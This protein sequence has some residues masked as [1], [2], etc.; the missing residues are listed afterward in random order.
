MSGLEEG[1]AQLSHQ[2]RQHRVYLNPQVSPLCT[3][4]FREGAIVPCPPL[5]RLD[6]FTQNF[7]YTQQTLGSHN[8]VE[9]EVKYKEFNAHSLGGFYQ[10]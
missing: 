7:V 1:E 5:P 10:I 8:I 9:N 2:S 3:G 6:F 4:V